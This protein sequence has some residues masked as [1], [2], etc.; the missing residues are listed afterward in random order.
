MRHAWCDVM[1]EHAVAKKPLDFPDDVGA[2][3]G[4]C[5]RVPVR[6]RALAPM[7]AIGGGCSQR[8]SPPTAASALRPRHATTW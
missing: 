2:R 6:C 3:T 5:S 7:R 4:R 1:S 8:Y